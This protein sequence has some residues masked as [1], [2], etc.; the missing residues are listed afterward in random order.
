MR[1]MASVE[2]RPGKA[3]AS[4]RPSR[5]A[6]PL[7]AVAG[8]RGKS[9]VSWIL[10]SIVR[11]ANGSIGAWLTSGVYVDGERLEGELRPWSRVL[12]AAKYGELDVV[13]QE[14]EAAVVVGAGLPTRTYPCAVLTTIC[15]NDDSCRL[16]M[17]TELEERSLQ[18]VADAV[19]EDGFIVANADDLSVVATAQSAPAETIFFALH[20]ENPILQR[21][22]GDG[23]RAVWVEHGQ[24]VAGDATG[25]VPVV[26]VNEI[27][28]TLDGSF[29]FQVQNAMAAIATAL[30]IN[31]DPQVVGRALRTFL[32]ETDRQAG[33]CN[34]LVARGAHIVVDSPNETWTLKMLARG[35]KHH[36][37]RRS[38]VVSGCFPN[39]SLE[40][41][42]EAGRIL[43]T[44]GGVVI[45]HNEDS[46]DPRLQSIKAGIASNHVPPLVLVLGSESAAI[47]QMLQ[48]VNTGDTALVLA[49]APED[50]LNQITTFVDG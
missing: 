48:S 17:S 29:I 3:F 43:G 37:R 11:A 12:L 49:E 50:V 7:I 35:V 38:I 13:I 20:P 36:P 10:E 6:L 16:S 40:D 27:P 19:R 31:V 34:V 9:T 1:Q 18:A 39:L 2:D 46:Q 42:R 33:S 21:H 41:T 44:L 28:A 25:H 26:A 15:G 22:L 4:L 47:D 45:L 23:G 8:S 5:T 30:E 14:M 32:P 24:I